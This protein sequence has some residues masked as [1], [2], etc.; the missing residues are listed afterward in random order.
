LQC[1]RDIVSTSSC[2]GRSRAVNQPAT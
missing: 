2:Y 1:V